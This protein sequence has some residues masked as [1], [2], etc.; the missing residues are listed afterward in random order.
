MRGQ[1]ALSKEEVFNYDAMRAD[2]EKFIAKLRKRTSI[3]SHT[4]TIA[5]VE[6]GDGVKAILAQC[7]S[8]RQ[9]V[10]LVSRVDT[11]F[12]PVAGEPLKLP[13]AGTFESLPAAGLVGWGGNR[14]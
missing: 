13:T 1:T 10:A 5:D 3:L 12:M 6:L 8:R 9:G 14:D 11:T 7:E 2:L 4:L